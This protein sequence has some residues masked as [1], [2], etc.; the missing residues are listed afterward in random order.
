MNYSK[1]NRSAQ[2]SFDSIAGAA[3][4]S[5]PT[6]WE[7]FWRKQTWS[8]VASGDQTILEFFSLD[9][10]ATQSG[11]TI[12]N[13]VVLDG[14]LADIDGDVNSDRKVDAAD[15][16]ILALNWQQAVTMGAAVTEPVTFRANEPESLRAVRG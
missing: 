4:D 14:G 9:N 11:A 13:I 15:L 12:D 6:G 10:P 5:E 1:V 3:A 16:N 7:V 8:F 2:F